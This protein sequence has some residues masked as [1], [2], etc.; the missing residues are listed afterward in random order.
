MEFSK[1]DLLND[2]ELEQL[3]NSEF[4]NEQADIVQQ[5]LKKYCLIHENVLFILQ[6]NIT[7]KREE[8]MKMSLLKRITLFLQK[9]FQ[10][11][12]KNIQ[13]LLQMKYPKT[14]FSHF[15]NQAVEKYYPQMYDALKVDDIKFDFT[16]C[17]IHFKNGYM[18]LKENKFKQRDVNKHYI[19]QCINRDYKPSTKAQQEEIL[20]HIKKIYPRDEDLKC[21]LLILGSA[22]SGK[23]N[24]DQETLF[25]L[26]TGSSGKSFI[27]S[28]T[29]EAIDCYFKE[30]QNDTFS[31][32][33]T[34][35]DKILN[36]FLK[37]Q[38]IRI[39]WINELKDSKMCDSLFKSF[40]EGKLQTTQLYKDGSDSFPHYSKCIITANTMPYINVDTG[41]DRRFKGYTHSAVF[42]DD[43]S[44]VD[45]KKNIHLKDKHLLDKLVEKQ[46]LNAWFDILAQ[47]CQNWLNGEK[48]KFNEN[49]EETK[50][51]VMNSND[52][53]KDFI[54]ANLTITN[55]DTD[56]IGK[57]TMHE[58]FC[59]MYPKK[60]LTVLQLIT[61][62]KE[63]N[64]KYFSQYRCDNLQGCYVGVKFKDDEVSEHASL[65]PELDGKT[66]REVELE[67]EIAKLRKQLEQ[68]SKPK[69]EK[70]NDY[71]EIFDK[72]SS[73][74]DELEA[75]LTALTSTENK[76]NNII[77]V[78]DYNVDS[79]DD[80]RN[81]E[82]QLKKQKKNKK[83]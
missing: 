78:D 47:H 22:L 31:Q 8:D 10:N 52:I 24:I 66:K 71:K 51:T 7:Y 77:I 67:Q 83:V 1:T 63:K 43:V 2:V 81:I 46:L 38:Y 69:K 42:Q 19:T 34:K 30:L 44:K 36:T 72:P 11:L 64:I 59:R 29:K 70:I 15:K 25:L 35:L 48:V 61:A 55:V 68:L 17:E 45:E 62:I 79:L 33:N 82:A 20:S 54:D 40:C 73:D 49:F 80:L 65:Y 12:S 13:E 50:N 41:V 28:L 53:I 21:I 32:S 75:E 76:I 37:A 3:I 58:S 27:L 57:I 60:H 26:G 6:P 9:S 39:T 16:L 5:K 56:R 74:I 4:P 23:S 14:L 18:D